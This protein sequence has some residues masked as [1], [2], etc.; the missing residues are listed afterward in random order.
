VQVAVPVAVVAAV[1]RLVGS[2]VNTIF[3]SVTETPGAVVRSVADTVPAVTLTRPEDHRK[4][5]IRLRSLVRIS[6][7]TTST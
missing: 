5:W 4:A 7:R 3:W 1:H 2:A 6:G